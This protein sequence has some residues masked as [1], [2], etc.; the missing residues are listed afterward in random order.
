MSSTRSIVLGVGFVAGS[1]AAT[2][3]PYVEMDRTAVA[4]GL[5]VGH[6]ITGSIDCRDAG[7]VRND[8]PVGTTAVLEYEL[9]PPTRCAHIDLVDAKGKVVTNWTDLAWCNGRVNGVTVLGDG[10][11]SFVRAV[12]DSCMGTTLTLRFVPAL[13]E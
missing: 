2:S 4:R 6:E 1:C 9:Q 8:L 13:R 5:T 12:A 3:S 7:I 11:R 10:G